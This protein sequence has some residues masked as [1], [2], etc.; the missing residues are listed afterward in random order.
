MTSVDSSSRESLA[1]DTAYKLYNFQIFY[2]SEK[3]KTLTQQG[4]FLVR[5]FNNGF[6]ASDLCEHTCL[7]S[8]GETRHTG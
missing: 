4:I 6:T 8:T 2:L 3:G 5:Y 1:T 7:I